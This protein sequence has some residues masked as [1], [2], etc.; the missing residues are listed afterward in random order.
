LRLPRGGGGVKTAGRFVVVQF[1]D[2]AASPRSID[3]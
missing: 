2:R 3:V 1:S